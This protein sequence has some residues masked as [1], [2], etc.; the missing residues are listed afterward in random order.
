MVQFPKIK[1]KQKRISTAQRVEAEKKVKRD[2]IASGELIPEVNIGMVGHV[3]HGKTTLTQMLTGKW[4]DTHSEEIKRGITIRLGYADAVFYYCEKCDIYGISKKCQSCFGD[5]VAK[6]AVSFIDAPGHETLMATVLSGTS[7]MDGALLLIAANEKCPQPQTAEH[8]K[9]LDIVGI[10]N[11]IIVQN[12]I[13]LVSEEEALQ[14][15]K[16]IKDFIKGTVAEN[17]PIIPVSAMHSVNID[18][19][20]KTIEETIPT[21]KRDLSVD[22]KFFIARSFDVNRPGTAIT[23]LVGSVIGGSLVS[24]TLKIGDELEV[25][26]GGQTGEKWLPLKTKIIDIV[27]A[28]RRKEARPGGLVALQTDLDPALSRGDGLSGH[29][30]GS[31]GKMPPTWDKI[32]FKAELFDHVIGAGGNQKVEPIRTNDVLMIT[33]A[34]AK[35]VGVVT[36]AH[37]NVCEMKLKI[38][39]C[40]EKK[41]RIA[42]FKQ[43]GGRW[44]LIG[45]GVLM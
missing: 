24:G 45:S 10:K 40:A 19:L 12:K 34:I 6:R 9:A 33:A 3:D 31:P 41:D 5:C 29:I 35:T 15:Y 17:A 26:P 44:H 28:G 32:K 27:Q 25:R 21:P 23:D 38:P 22:P 43:V 14:N 11:I 42:I 8:L 7:L 16:E 1:A 36:T 4:T 2:E 13:D 18:A 20:I 39:I 37:S 30:A